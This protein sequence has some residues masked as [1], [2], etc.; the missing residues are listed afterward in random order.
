MTVVTGHGGK[1][2]VNLDG[3]L[4]TVRDLVN[5]WNTQHI[6]DTLYSLSNGKQKETIDRT[7]SFDFCRNP[8]YINCMA[9]GF[10]LNVN[11]HHKVGWD[12]MTKEYYDSLPDSL[13]Q[14]ADNIKE[15]MEEI[16]NKS[17]GGK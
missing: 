12:K 1:E 6:E 10:R 17:K 9:A 2:V 16:K 15:K 5:Y 8:Q 4:K 11:D 7:G 13:K 14:Y 3:Q